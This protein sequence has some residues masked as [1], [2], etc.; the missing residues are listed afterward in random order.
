MASQNSAPSATAADPNASAVAERRQFRG[1][2]SF[3]PRFVTG[4]GPSIFS[5][6]PPS[7]LSTTVHVSSCLPLLFDPRNPMHDSL[8]LGRLRL[9][10]HAI[11]L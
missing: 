2:V 7:D 5:K 6:Q 10:H 9:V 1:M 3:S 4:V 11:A 8:F